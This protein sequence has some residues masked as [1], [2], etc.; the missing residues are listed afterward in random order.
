MENKI[1]ISYAITVCNELEEIK[2]LIDFLLVYK[3]DED[4]LVVLVDIS[5]EGNGE[6]RGWL[7]EKKQSLIL[8]GD[9]IKILEDTFEGHFANWKNKLTS[10]CTGDYIVNIDA[11]ELPNNQLVL[12]LPTIL[13]Y[14]PEVD[15]YCV[16]RVNTVE[17]LTPQHI[18]KWGWRVDEKG[19]VNWPDYQMR[20]YKNRPEIK[21]KNKVHEVLEGYKKITTLP[22]Q[23][24]FA[25]YHPKTI[26]RQQKQNNYYDTL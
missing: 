9:P 25:L 2:K 13:E 7:N 10:Y 18:A 8:Q 23:E 21:W 26:E 22:L 5:K 3:Q 12:N 4:E 20:V 17:G 24:E 11:D 19:W 6:L 1:K 14:N 16:P 15:V